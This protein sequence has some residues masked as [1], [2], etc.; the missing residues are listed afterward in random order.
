MVINVKLKMK[1]KK[2]PGKRRL[3]AKTV[4]RLK[5]AGYAVG[6]MALY[7]VI[8]GAFG[9]H[10]KKEIPKRP[11]LQCALDFNGNKKLKFIELTKDEAKQVKPPENCEKM[12]CR[13][14]LYEN[15]FHDCEPMT[16]ENLTELPD[17]R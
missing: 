6:F 1:D 9:L 3:S 4:D 10:M 5:V 17:D 11:V 15:E 13:K 2:E 14:V 8:M 7:C 16:E 12:L